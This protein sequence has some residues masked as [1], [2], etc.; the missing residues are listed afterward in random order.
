MFGKI[1]KNENRTQF[2]PFAIFSDL[3]L[4]DRNG[5]QHACEVQQVQLKAS[6]GA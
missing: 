1:N 6:S 2:R 3:R 4:A 5:I